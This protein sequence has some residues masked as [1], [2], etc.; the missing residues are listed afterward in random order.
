MLPEPLARSL[1]AEVVTGDEEGVQ[2]CNVSQHLSAVRLKAAPIATWQAPLS[3]TS[4]AH[5]SSMRLAVEGLSFVFQ[6]FRDMNGHVAALQIE[7]SDSGLTQADEDTL[8]KM[9]LL[10][11]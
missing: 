7:N 6:R 2:R 9:C 10:G 11:S 8:R 3:F 5:G 4:R 1:G